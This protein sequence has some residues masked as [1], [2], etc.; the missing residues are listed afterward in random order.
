MTSTDNLKIE[1]QSDKKEKNTKR[2]PLTSLKN[3]P[4]VR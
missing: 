3:N 4:A 1:L 2:N